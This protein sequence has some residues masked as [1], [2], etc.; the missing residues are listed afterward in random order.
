MKTQ[1][2]NMDSTKNKCSLISFNCKGISRSLECVKTLSKEVDIIALQETWLLQHDIPLL[3]TVNN[4]FAYTGNSAVDLSAG[5]L[6]GRPYGGVTLL[7]R[8][9]RFPC[10]SVISCRSVRLVAIKISLRDRSMIVFSVYMPNDES[11]NMTEFTECLGEICAIIDSEAVDLVYVLGDLNAHINMP[12]FHELKCFCAEQS[13]CIVDNELLPVDSYTYVSD[14]HGCRRWLDHCVTTTAARNTVESATIHYDVFWSDH[15]P[16][17]IIINLQ[18]NVSKHVINDNNLNN[19]FVKGVTWGERDQKQINKYG[20]LCNVK[21]R[22]ID[23]PIELREC[24][25]DVCYNNNH[26]KVI[27]NMYKSVVTILSEASVASC[28]SGQRRRGGY[29]T[30]WKTRAG[31]S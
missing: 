12:F 20:S 19:K 21:L 1:N 16:I 26:R 30:G 27:D 25:D 4:N 14:S 31:G 15:I 5:V 10:V 6:R 2:R 18:K 9:D 3:A 24:C 29:V 13:M 8:K 17:E 28:D 22:D 23:F 11:E 7:W